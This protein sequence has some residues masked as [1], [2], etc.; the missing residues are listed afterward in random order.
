M[1]QRSALD[2]VNKLKKDDVNDMQRTKTF[3][4]LHKRLENLSTIEAVC[5]EGGVAVVAEGLNATSAQLR[6]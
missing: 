5:E 6:K 1:D 2:Y 3:Y 4:E